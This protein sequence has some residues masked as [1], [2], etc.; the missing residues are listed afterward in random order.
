MVNTMQQV[1]GA[2]CTAIA[3]FLLATGQSSFYAAGGTGET[4]AFAQGSH[5]GFMFA[6][7]LAVVA[8]LLA[9]SIRKPAASAAAAPAAAHAAEQG[10]AA[11]ATLQAPGLAQFMKREVFTLA[12]TDSALDAMRLFAEKKISGAPVVDAAGKL[13]GFL[14]DGDVIGMLAKQEAAFT[15]FY[16]YT[17]D[18]NDETFAQKVEALRSLEVGRIATQQVIAVHE[19]DDMRDVCALLAQHRLK[20]APVLN[21]AGD[22]VGILSRTDIT[23]YTVGLYA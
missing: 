16:A 1:V 4:L 19:T 18:S 21:A 14:S 12:E 20:K 13:T 5:Y 9:L 7:A 8:F 23:R 15:S 10:V 3:T 6:L 2:I 11:P 17:L 22:M